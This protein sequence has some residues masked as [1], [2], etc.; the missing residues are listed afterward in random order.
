MASIIRKSHFGVPA[1]QCWAA[2]RN[3]GAVHERL[4][5]GFVT[6]SVLVAEGVREV[7]FCTGA[8]ARERLVGVNDEA[9]RLAYSVVSGP[10]GSTH[11]NASA[12][13]VP[14]GD[15]ACTFVWIIDVL[16]DELAGRVA[17][18]MDA[19]LAAIRRTVEGST[20]AGAGS[21]AGS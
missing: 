5:R 7:T 3:F 11:Y 20:T 12:Q 16:P 9:M 18:L 4:A 2:V 17:Q 15:A 14:D 21:N 13:V 19:G 6:N 10:L 1:G 8:V